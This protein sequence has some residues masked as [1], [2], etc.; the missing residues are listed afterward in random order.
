MPRSAFATS[1]VGLALIVAGFGMV[2]SSAWTLANRG[3][4]YWQQTWERRLETLEVDVTGP[5]FGV[6]SP[7]QTDSIA[8]LRSRRFSVSKLAIAL[9]DFITCVFRSIVN[10]HS[11]S[12]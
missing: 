12:T 2:Y 6:D 3:S 5:L 11:V 7:A 10:T 8:W 4:K 1:S 9:S